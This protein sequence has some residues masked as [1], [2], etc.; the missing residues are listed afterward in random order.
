MLG[1]EAHPASSGVNESK[2]SQPVGRY[3]PVMVRCLIEHRRGA[4]QAFTLEYGL[5]VQGDSKEDVKQRL[6]RVI[7][8][9]VTDAL[10]GEDREHAEILLSRRATLGVYFRYYLYSMLSTLRPGSG[11]SRE[12][13]AYREPLALE[14]RLCPP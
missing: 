11:G 3:V 1:H 6:E 12:H 10:I 2:K 5:A 9:Y 14:P 13:K 8:S 4:W 7:I